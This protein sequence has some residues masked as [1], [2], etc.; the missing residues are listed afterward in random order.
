MK[1]KF[2]LIVISIFA[3]LLSISLASSMI[4]NSVE[5]GELYPGQSASL[6]VE[7]KNTLNGDVTD[8]SLVLELENTSFTS[9]G[10]SEDSEDEI[11]EDDK[12]TFSFTLK[13]PS[14][15]KPGDYNIPYTLTYLDSDDEE[16]TRTGSIGVTVGAKTEI[17]YAVEAKNNVAGEQGKVSIKIINSGLGDVGFVNVKITSDSGLEILSS[18]EEYVGTIDSDDFELATFEVIFEK[19]SASITA[20]ITYKDFDNQEQTETITLPV[21]VYSREKALELGLIKKSNYTTY[22]IVAVIIIVWIIYRRIKKRR[23]NSKKEA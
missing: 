3:V 4:I 10:S 13:A 1:T 14:N 20:K 6:K 18:K 23:K 12:E 15:I 19:T 8:V 2:N 11:N 9:V 16:K 5:V 7:V 22:G 21:K 17:S